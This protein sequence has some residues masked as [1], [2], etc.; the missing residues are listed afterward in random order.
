VGEDRLPRT[1]AVI[2]GSVVALRTWLGLVESMAWGN[3]REELARFDCDAC[4]HA[5]QQTS[6]RQS[7]LR[8]RRTGR[9]VFATWPAA[10]VPLGIQHAYTGAA[11]RSASEVEFREK[12]AALVDAVAAQPF[13]DLARMQAAAQELDSW[14]RALEVRLAS[15]TCDRSRALAMLR[16]TLTC[17]DE[18]WPDFST[19][20]QLAMAAGTIAAELQAP[21]P[22]R[23]RFIASRANETPR[24]IATRWKH[25][26]E[27]YRAW[28]LN[29]RQPGVLRAND[30]FDR[31]DE[32][33]LLYRPVSKDGMYVVDWLE[34]ERQRV[35]RY[36]PTG[37]LAEAARVRA[38][39]DDQQR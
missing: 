20:R 10:L 31:L 21:Y 1:E 12:Y 19:A 25:D 33:L 37:F 34:E 8:G 6:W 16:A 32:Q 13:A 29:V 15:T 18:E 26:L 22:P 3:G 14:C 17:C 7:P 11:E 36:D 9:P 23:E 28:Q 35:G 39:L 5:L 38:L 4:H 24:D 27:L 30:M 2:V